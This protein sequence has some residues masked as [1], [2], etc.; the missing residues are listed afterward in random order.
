MTNFSNNQ[1]KLIDL[2]IVVNSKS[3]KDFYGETSH[4]YDI[5]LRNHNI[6]PEKEEIINKILKDAY[7]LNPYTGSK[8]RLNQLKTEFKTNANKLQSKRISKRITEKN[9]KLKDSL[10]SMPFKHSK[11]YNL[12]NSIDTFKLSS[13]GNSPVLLNKI[14]A[15]NKKKTKKRKQKKKTKKKPHK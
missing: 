10:K 6:T 2:M 11:N 7:E 5:F 8:I 13:R 9:L 14:D 3:L 15:G 1:I 4:G 12:V